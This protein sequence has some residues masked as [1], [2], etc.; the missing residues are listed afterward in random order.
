MRRSA[1]LKA[2]RAQRRKDIDMVQEAVRR[3]V[4]AAANEAW[5]KKPLVTVFVT[6]L[7][8]HGPDAVD[9]RKGPMRQ[10]TN[11][12]AQMLGRLNHVAIAV[13]DLAAASAVYRDTLGAKVSEPQ[14]LPEHGVTVVFIDTGNTQDRAAGA[15][16]RGVA[17]RGFSREE[18]LRRH[19]PYLLRGGRYPCCARPAEGRARAFLATA[20]RR[21]AHTASRCFFSTRRISSEPWWSLNRHE[22]GSR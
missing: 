5:G 13:P 3:A 18:P 20:R 12:E 8:P 9:V 2:S 22:A 19:A 1:P 11:R 15:A 6:R 4:R 16:G 17:D 10:G 7:S 14:A 21:S